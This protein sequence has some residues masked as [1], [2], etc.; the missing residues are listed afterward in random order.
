MQKYSAVPELLFQS[1]KESVFV[2]NV[3][4]LIGLSQTHVDYILTALELDD[5]DPSQVARRYERASWGTTITMV[6]YNSLLEQLFPRHG[7]VLERL[8]KAKQ[9]VETV[10]QL[11]LFEGE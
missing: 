7:P 1:L 3:N 6:Y 10:E 5:L 8:K 11:S 4:G 9:P 2:D